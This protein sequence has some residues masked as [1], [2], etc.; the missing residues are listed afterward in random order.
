MSAET[1]AELAAA[2]PFE[3]IAVAGNPATPPDLLEKLACRAEA[4]VRRAVAAS[5]HCPLSVL[6]FLALD[7]EA[8][9][10]QAIRGNPMSPEAL[11]VHVALKL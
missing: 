5:V 2:G 10:L 1:L 8:V 9:V 7:D 4:S 3:A 6:S 11:R